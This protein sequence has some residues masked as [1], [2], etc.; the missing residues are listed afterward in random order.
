MWPSCILQRASG[1][2]CITRVLISKA[3][4]KQM[5]KLG[6]LYALSDELVSS[7]TLSSPVSARTNEP[8]E[9][10]KVSTAEPPPQA[11]GKQIS[12][13]DQGMTCLTCG[14]GTVS[15]LR[16]DGQECHLCKQLSSAVTP[17]HANGTG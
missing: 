11:G 3:S 5:S 12:E 15:T 1:S 7:A 4:A 6:S 16:L 8:D 13:A 14:I 10:V 2:F 9:Q 17:F